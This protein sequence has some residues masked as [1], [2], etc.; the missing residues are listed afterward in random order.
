MPHIFNVA[1]IGGGIAGASFAYRVAG[2]RSLILLERENQVGYHSTGRSAAE[3][4][5][6]FQSPWVSTLAESSYHFLI[7]PPAGFTDIGLLIPRGSLVIATRERAHLVAPAFNHILSTSP[8]SR[9]LHPDDALA[10][11]P[12]LKA[13][14]VEAAFY[15]PM[16]WDME[17]DSLLQ[18][19]LRLALRAGAQVQL[20]SPVTSI[21]RE[22]GIYH[23][24]TPVGEVLYRKIVNAVGAWADDFAAKAG[25]DRL[26]IVPYRRTAITVDGP[27]DIDL[28]TLPA[29]NEVG[30]AFYFKPASGRIMVSPA[31][32]TPSGACDA[33]PE[34]LDI[35]YA[36]NF[37]SE[38][39][40]LPI[41]Q[42]THKWAGLRSFAP[43][44]RQVVGFSP[45]DENFFWLAGQGGSGILTSPAL[46]AWA[47]GLFL[48]G[49]PP[50]ELCKAGLQ[51]DVFSPGRLSGG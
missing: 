10:M 23:L 7:N 30:E 41:N 13:D 17:V 39:T 11:V 36:A 2:H 37:L 15:D 6:Q 46:S 24:R 9:L 34:E 35:A 45:Q 49:A 5:S 31:D 18:G 38:S 47:A 27:K 32:A 43:D 12:F 4:S 28:S 14:Y 20:A 26:R 19:Y 44:K 8:A 48:E 1:V 51:P 16:N 25:L 40:T 50:E 21:H 29:V 22:G 42:I 33:Q 3:F